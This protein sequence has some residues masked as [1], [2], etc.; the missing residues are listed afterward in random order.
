MY[1]HIKCFQRRECPKQSKK[2]TKYCYKT[3]LLKHILLFWI[4]KTV[5]VNFFLTDWLTGWLAGW[6]AACL[7]DWLTDW[8]V[9]GRTDRPT[10]R[11]TGWLTDW[12]TINFWNIRWY[13]DEF[14]I[15]FGISFVLFVNRIHFSFLEIRRNVSTF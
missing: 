13:A 15:I 11:L 14:L 6:L 7:T 2:A 5:Q 4:W 1:W 3:I 10:D 9:D 12:P 8:L